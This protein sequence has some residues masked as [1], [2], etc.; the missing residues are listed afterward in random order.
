M[1]FAIFF[2]TKCYQIE[3]FRSKTKITEYYLEIFYEENRI[4]INSNK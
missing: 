3:T 4:L 1:C 2:Y